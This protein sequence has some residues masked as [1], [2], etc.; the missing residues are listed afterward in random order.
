MEQN[1]QIPRKT[2]RTSNFIFL[3]LFSSFLLFPS[4]RQTTRKCF[5]RISKRWLGQAGMVKATELCCCER[6]V[7]SST[8]DILCT[9]TCITLNQHPWQPLDGKAKKSRMKVYLNLVQLFILSPFS[10]SRAF[11]TN[12][13]MR[14]LIRHHI[15]SPLRPQHNKAKNKLIRWSYWDSDFYFTECEVVQ[16]LRA[17]G[18]VLWLSIGWKDALGRLN[19]QLWDLPCNIHVIHTSFTLRPA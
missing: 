19:H 6:V 13:L 18:I 8:I 12:N 4:T 2:A 10:V 14:E 5:H 7:H 11:S 16:H 17:G 1:R 3:P 15:H 9:C